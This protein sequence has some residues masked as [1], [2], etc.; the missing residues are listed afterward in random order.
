MSLEEKFDKEILIVKRKILF[1]GKYFNGFLSKNK[2]NYKKI[3]L[4]NYE[5]MKRGLAEK[6]LN[7]KQPI[8]YFIII[9]DQ[10]KLFFAYQRS[11][12]HNEPRLKDKVSIG[13]GGHI[14]KLD[15]KGNN[16]LYKNIN[17]ELNEEIFF[18]ENYIPEFLGY[19][20]DDKNPVG[21]VHFGLLYLIKTNEEF[22][23]PKDREIARCSL[24]N[25]KRLDDLIKE[26][27][28]EGWSKIIIPE[29]KKYFQ[30]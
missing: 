20:N 5:F 12:S 8:P 1:L 9:N 17:R 19:I 6:N 24:L 18:N 27:D 13:L 3:I 23:Y 11:S 10:K 29:L 30:Q 16:I 25:I 4:K 15:T 26:S 7:Y 22:L 2:F 14:E 21:K 28:F